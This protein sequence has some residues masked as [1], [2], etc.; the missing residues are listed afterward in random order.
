LPFATVGQSGSPFEVP[1]A[2]RVES[3]GVRVGWGV[4]GG[5]YHKLAKLDTG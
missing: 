1:E 5:V 4:G 3:E 2:S